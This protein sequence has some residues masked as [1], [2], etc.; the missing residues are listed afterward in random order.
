MDDKIKV[1]KDELSS[2]ITDFSKTNNRYNNPKFIKSMN[3]DA[4]FVST[5]Y[6]RSFVDPTTRGI[7]DQKSIFLKD[8]IKAIVDIKK[9]RGNFNVYLQKIVIEK[10]FENSEVI[11]KSGI[12][13]GYYYEIMR[14]RK[15]PS[16]DKIIQIAIALDLNIKETNELLNMQGY[17]LWGEN[18]RDFIILYCIENN[19]NLIHVNMLLEEF[20]EKLLA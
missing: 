1:L 16:R 10:G 3:L 11:R 20:K 5:N 18:P 13:K 12:E 9:K 7:L 6:A 19:L 8:E 17:A 14:G 2:L 15:N 4:T